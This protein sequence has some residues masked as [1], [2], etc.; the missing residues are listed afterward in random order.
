MLLG[1]VTVKKGKKRNL[2]KCLSESELTVRI[3]IIE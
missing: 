3:T 2:A 1:S